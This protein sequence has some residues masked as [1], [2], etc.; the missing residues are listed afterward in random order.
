M[1]IDADTQANATSGLGILTKKLDF[2]IVNL[3]QGDTNTEDCI[4]ETHSPNLKII[5]GSIK[6]ADIEINIKN[7]NLN[8]LK[9]AIEILKN[10]FDFI[11]IDCTPSLG[12]I[13]LNSFV[14]ANSIIIPIQCEFYALNGL[15]KLLS[16]IK[17]IKKSFN[18]NL[19]IEGILMTMYDNQLSH[20]KHVLNELKIYFK[21]LIFK[22]IIKRNVSLSEAPSYGTSIFN[23]KINSEGSTNDLNLSREIMKNQTSNT[24]K[25]LGKKLPQIL[26]ETEE[27]IS[28]I[29]SAERR[30]LDPFKTFSLK[31]KNYD[32][33]IGYTKKEIIAQLGQEYNDI[34]SDRWM[35]HLTNK[36]SLIKKN[37]LYIYFDKNKVNFIKLRRFKFS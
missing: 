35:Y 1:L 3:F 37:Y 2:S 30:N 29:S 18:T 12:Y 32:K 6:L 8:R 34:H 19:S 27:E 9:S 28:I 24:Q 22:T 21:D 7:P 5:P 10:Q 15:S 26:K 4:L 36:I 16:T 20:N 33:L 13:T 23:Y 25:F 14:A 31:D 11:I 17:S